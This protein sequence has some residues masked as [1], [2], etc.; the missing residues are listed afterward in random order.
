MTDKSDLPKAAVRNPWTNE[1]IGDLESMYIMGYTLK[2]IAE[3][4]GNHGGRGNIY[5][6]LKKFGI[7]KKHGYRNKS[8]G[9]RDN[10]TGEMT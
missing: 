8:G 3:T 2:E 9:R 1:E 6:A 5:M 10:R 4:F 7:Y